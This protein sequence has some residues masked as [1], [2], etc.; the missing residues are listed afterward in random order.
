MI[1]LPGAIALTLTDFEREA[2]I[3]YLVDV[4]QRCSGNL[5]R[6]AKMAGRNR[7]AFVELVTAAELNELAHELREKA[8]DA[9][10]RLEGREPRKSLKP[11]KKRRGTEVAS[12]ET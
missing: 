10:Y 8:V 3:A 11:Y 12:V 6:A 9:R 4:I 1:Q 7:A 5:T 2:R